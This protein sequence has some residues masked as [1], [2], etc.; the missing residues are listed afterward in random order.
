MGSDPKHL[1][2]PPLSPGRDSGGYNAPTPIGIDLPG[3]KSICNDSEITPHACG[4]ADC[5]SQHIQ[6]E[7]AASIP[8]EKPNHSVQ[9]DGH[10]WATKPKQNMV[11]WIP[12]EE[13]R[14]GQERRYDPDRPGRSASVRSLG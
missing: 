14:D 4:N 8:P 7:A 6:S 5:T 10:G 12:E 3:T 11:S 1:N 2:C 9:E 13:V